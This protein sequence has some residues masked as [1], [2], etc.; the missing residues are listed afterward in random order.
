MSRTSATPAR[1]RRFLAPSAPRRG[2]D[3]PP[4]LASDPRF[5]LRVVIAAVATFTIG[6]AWAVIVVRSGGWTR[7]LPRDV[8]VLA[9]VHRHL[10]T[11]IDWVVVTLPWLGTNLV[12]IPVIGPVCWHLWKKRKR[13]DLALVIAVATIG[14]YLLGT[15]LK[16]AFERPRPALWLARGEYTG[17]AYPSGHVM[18]VTSVVGVVAVLLYEERRAIWPLVAWI[19]LLIA[20]CYARLYLGVHWPTDVVGGLLAGAVWFLGV[21][22]ARRTDAPD[23]ANGRPVS[24]PSL[25]SPVR[26]PVADR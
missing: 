25:R 13:P 26:L 10:P 15:A 11:V 22:W 5:W 21:L 23:S 4:Q 12:F 17:P 16:A 14:N 19:V 7:G 20:T 6:A 1:A 24:A 2:L 8:D 3:R 18:A 9:R